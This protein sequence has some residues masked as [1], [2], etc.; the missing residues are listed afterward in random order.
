MPM[1]SSPADRLPVE[2]LALVFAHLSTHDLRGL[3]LASV[4]RRWRAAVAATKELHLVATQALVNTGVAKLVAQHACLH[5]LHLKRQFS[6]QP[7][8]A[9]DIAIHQ[10]ASQ[11][12][13]HSTL[14]TIE[15]DSEHILPGAL[16]CPRLQVLR[17]NNR[18]NVPT[19]TTSEAAGENGVPAHRLHAQSRNLV[20]ILRNI[21][22][23]RTLHIVDPTLGNRS[24]LRSG[25]GGNVS[26][27]ETLVIHEL[28]AWTLM[29]LSVHIEQDN[30]PNLRHLELDGDLHLPT[31]FV[32][33]IKHHC[34]KLSVLKLQSLT[35]TPTNMYELMMPPALPL[36]LLHLRYCNMM[37]QMRSNSE[38]QAP[39]AAAITAS[40]S[41][42]DAPQGSEAHAYLRLTRYLTRFIPTL[43]QLSFEHCGATHVNIASVVDFRWFHTDDIEREL[44]DTT[45]NAALHMA[46]ASALR[47]L[48]IHYLGRERY[49]AADLRR[50][51]L[52]YPHL[53]SLTTHTSA[54]DMTVD[55]LLPLGSL[56][57]LELRYSSDAHVRLDE[58]DDNVLAEPPVSQITKLSSLSTYSAS[59]HGARLVL[60]AL[61]S[62]A[63][64]LTCLTINYP[65]SVFVEMLQRHHSA[66]SL[67]HLEQLTLR[68]MGSDA[69]TT[70]L[71]LLSLFLS[72]SP[73]RLSHVHLE[74][75]YH[76]LRDSAT[77]LSSLQ[78][79][80]ACTSRLS[81]L[82]VH[83]Y[84]VSPACLSL[85]TGAVPSLSSLE[86]VGARAL[87]VNEHSHSTLG[88]L[89][90]S[91][92][93]LRRLL[94]SVDSIH[95]PLVDTDTNIA[96]PYVPLAPG[97]SLPHSRSLPTSLSTS[98]DSAMSLMSRLSRTIER[99]FHLSHHDLPLPQQQQQQQHRARASSRPFDE[100]QQSRCMDYAHLL[101]QKFPWLQVVKVWPKLESDGSDALST[102]L[103]TS[104]D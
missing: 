5:S 75:L 37:F 55:T 98:T 84:E 59:V 48:D 103:R 3:R 42:V 14:L 41:A 17:L 87:C 62:L 20:F 65:K 78:L 16:N 12:L 99:S 18:F 21:P 47:R 92:R 39:L 31:E 28:S 53:E 35:F 81:S 83:G 24:A 49:S 1:E 9:N 93:R 6:F 44:Y 61:P 32:Y 52:F 19:T 10:A 102:A 76:D 68:S 67:P 26:M 74:C 27:L 50:I 8:P 82:V 15:S 33:A 89:L 29:N 86:L 72:Q 13:G 30:L 63:S 91:T 104:S 100:Y 38:L 45:S 77:L 80:V 85:L 64:T 88:A 43:R 34:P 4:S 101:R 69:G 57:S 96:L 36:T 73:R 22:T 23:L 90:S 51:M 97:A 56:R 11:F 40:S 95:L 46:A 66:V 7:A 94:V 60:S 71:S 79:V 70:N 54:S 2:V 25:A 58:D